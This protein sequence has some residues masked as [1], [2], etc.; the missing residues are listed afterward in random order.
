MEPL[1]NSYE[2]E[3]LLNEAYQELPEHID[4][5]TETKE[6]LAQILNEV[7]DLNAHRAYHNHIHA[8]HVMKRSFI[9]WRELQNV[10]PDIFTND[11]YELLAIAACG[12]DKY[13]Q[14]TQPG[15]NE[16]QSAVDSVHHMQN[17]HTILEQTRVFEATCTTQVMRDAE[18]VIVQQFM[19]TGS[20]DPLKFVLA[21]AD[22]N[23]VALEGVPRMVEDAVNLYIEFNDL[24]ISASLWGHSRDLGKFL[25][26]QA[27][28]LR[29]RLEAL[30]ED[31]D[32]YF[33][34]SSGLVNQSVKQVMTTLFQSSK[35]TLAVAEYLEL[36]GCTEAIMEHLNKTVVYIKYLPASLLRILYS[37]DTDNSNE[38]V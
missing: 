5:T 4:F 25:Q 35:H 9:I 17:S 38:L 14:F 21:V 30:S 6:Q 20:R 15:K 37:S 7:A 1:H 11:A 22:I 2:V 10:L 19:K 26:A 13:Q 31:I 29:S 8:V 32:Y 18:G 34:P 36:P 12:H 23:G 28:F 27:S 16:R 24:D 33:P 3:R